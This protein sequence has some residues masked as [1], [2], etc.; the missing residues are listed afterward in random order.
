[1]SGCLPPHAR[2]RFPEPVPPPVIG[3]LLPSTSSLPKSCSLPSGKGYFTLG[4]YFIGKGF[5]D[6]CFFFG[7][8]AKTLSSV[9][10][11]SANKNTRQIK[12]RKI[13]KNSKTFF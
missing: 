12:N 4:K 13:R 5:F 9:E 2:H 3:S 1:M 7:H 6:E 10:K 8:S 11:H